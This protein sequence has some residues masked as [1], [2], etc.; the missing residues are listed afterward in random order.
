[1]FRLP[2]G[3]FNKKSLVL[4]LFLIAGLLGGCSKTATSPG[5]NTQGFSRIVTTPNFVNSWYN[6]APETLSVYKSTLVIAKEDSVNVLRLDD[7]SKT[8]NSWD[9][10]PGIWFSEIYAAAVNPNNG[11][12]FAV[13]YDNYEVYQ[14]TAGGV[15][16]NFNNYNFSEP[17]DVATDSNGNYYVADSDNSE[18]EEFDAQNHLIN[19]WYSFGG[20]S[21]DYPTGVALDVQ[22]NLYIADYDDAQIFELAAGTNT[23][24]NTW[25]LPYYDY[26][27]EMAIDGNGVVYAPLYEEKEVAEYKA[28]SALPFLTWDGSQGGGTKFGGPDGICLLQNGDILVSDY[29]KDNIQEFKP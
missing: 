9:Y 6:Y 5:S 22:N 19:S 12:I 15:A 7:L 1:M 11:H 23:L 8:I 24:L 17:E 25:N 3:G 2:I 10:Y 4:S 27:Y 16:V 20:T 28:G 18:V 21:L 29:E 26:V 14:F 13:D